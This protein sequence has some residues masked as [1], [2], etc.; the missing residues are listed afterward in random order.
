M[1]TSSYP[2]IPGVFHGVNDNNLSIERAAPGQKITVLGVTTA[3]IPINEPV[4]LRSASSDR[5]NVMHPANGTL[6][7]I[8]SELNRGMAEAGKSVAIEYVKI[9]HGWGEEGYGFIN[10]PDFDGHIITPTE[11]FEA[12]QETYDLLLNNNMDMVYV[13]GIYADKQTSLTQLLL[14]NNSTPAY[15][16]STGDLGYQLANFCED[17]TSENQSCLSGIGRLPIR[18]KQFYEALDADYFSNLDLTAFNDVVTIDASTKTVTFANPFIASAMPFKGSSILIHYPTGP[19]RY[20][21]V[22]LG[23]TLFTSSSSTSSSSIS[24][25]Q[26][27]LKE[28]PVEYSSGPNLKVRLQTF[29]T[30]SV[31]YDSVLTESIQDAYRRAF[32]GYHPTDL[33]S[34]NKA[35]LT[36]FQEFLTGAENF[37]NMLNFDGTTAASSALYPTNYRFWKA[38]GGAVAFPNG[39][40]IDIVDANG[41]PIDMGKWLSLCSLHGKS[42]NSF[43][44]QT[45]SLYGFASERLY[46]SNGV[47]EYLAMALKLPENV[48]TTNRPIEGFFAERDIKRST[49]DSLIG[50][51]FLVTTSD[52]TSGFVIAAGNTAAYLIDNNRRSDYTFLTT[53][54]ITAKTLQ[55]VRNV[56]R[57]YIGR[58]LTASQFRAIDADLTVMYNNLVKDGYIDKDYDFALDQT[59][60]QKVLG[61]ATLRQ[62]IRPAFELRKIFGETNLRK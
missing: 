23:S 50:K 13:C 36:E 59:A 24:Y 17:S 42:S 58:A 49:L 20:V 44:D 41:I 39:S 52:P 4:L 48:S 60:D 38:T 8:P 16:V 25:D 61:H 10:H 34:T 62:S 35:T 28:T 3:D 14:P 54:R 32:R 53:V 33:T 19:R 56:V 5:F 18:I 57:P 11:R 47:G 37:T 51:R 55:G 43:G 21:V 7:A 45:L 31:M 22:D 15:S 46:V 6:P 27:I 29:D 26:V 1:P 30:T 12:L 40:N 2:N 9:A